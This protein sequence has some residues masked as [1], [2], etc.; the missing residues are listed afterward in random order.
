MYLKIYRDLK[1][2]KKIMNSLYKNLNLKYILGVLD[3]LAENS[4][5]SSTIVSFQ[6]TSGGVYD[7]FDLIFTFFQNL[8]L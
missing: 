7:S 5:D 6:D 2:S 1:L 8:I 3:F 4:Y